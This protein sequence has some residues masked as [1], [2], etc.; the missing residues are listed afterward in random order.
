[1]TYLIGTDEAGYGPNLGP[2]VISATVWRVADSAPMPDLYDILSESVS[3]TSHTN[4]QSVVTIADS[5]ALYKSGGGLGRLETNLYA[6][7]RSIGW[8][9]VSWQD[10]WRS[11]APDCTELR[12][13]IPWYREVSLPLPV[14]ANPVEV[15][16]NAKTLKAVLASHKTEVVTLRSS[17]IFPEEFNGLVQKF[18]TKG[19]ALSNETFKLLKDV[20]QGIGNE[21]ICVVCDKHGGR[22]KYGPLLQN[23]FTD[24]WIQVC[25]EGR[26]ES[27][28]RLG[29]ADR[30]VEIQFRV[31]GESFLPTA[32]ASMCSKY[33]RELAMLA[34]NDFWCTQV[35]DLKPTAGYPVDARRFKREISSVQRALGIEDH[36]LWRNR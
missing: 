28:Y 12:R 26:N 34:F 31:G 25:V 2:L 24:D 17:A 20:M 35:A 11:L 36:V 4:A 23:I 16:A 8:N 27:V 29:P 14:A 22:N 19:A 10:V 33:L 5:K 32:L 7:A 3:D 1:M 15:E 21:P 6:V 18:G 13:Q 30:P 9:W